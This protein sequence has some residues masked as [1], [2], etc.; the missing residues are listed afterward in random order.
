MKTDLNAL[1]SELRK[2]T[3]LDYLKKELNQIKTDIKKF[4]LRIKVSPQAR[5]RLRLLEKSFQ[6]IRGKVATLQKQV[7]R[8]V[9][10]LIHTL[11]ATG[12]GATTSPRR[13]TRKKTSGR[14][15]AAKKTTRKSGRRSTP[16]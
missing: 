1:K 5:T 2:L 3:D 8:E 16:R 10:K 4:D 6:D 11:R 9:N 14:K 15:S 13:S 12:F 7:D